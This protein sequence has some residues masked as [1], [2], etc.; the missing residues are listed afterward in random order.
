M[1]SNNNFRKVTFEDDG[2][3]RTTRPGKGQSSRIIELTIKWSRG[4]IKNEK[5]AIAFLLGL[6]VIA[7]ITSIFLITGNAGEKQ[8][9]P[10]IMDSS[11]RPGMRN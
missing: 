1:D 6:I 5:K 8:A 10:K 2:F 4:L 9:P 3:S 11:F 7:F